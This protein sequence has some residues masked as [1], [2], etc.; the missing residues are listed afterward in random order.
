MVNPQKATTRE[1]KVHHEFV[2]SVKARAVEQWKKN[3]LIIGRP[4]NNY[5]HQ[6]QNGTSTALTR[7]KIF[8]FHTT[9]HTVI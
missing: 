6:D 2:V 3:K 7:V 5:L 9:T 8:H 1:T 4:N